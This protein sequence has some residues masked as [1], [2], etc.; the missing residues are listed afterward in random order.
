MTARWPV[1][2]QDIQ[3]FVRRR[4]NCQM[5]WPSLEKTVFEWPEAQVWERL[6]V[7]WVYVKDQ[8]KVFV[9]VYAGFCWIDAFPAGDRTTE[10]VKVYIS[11]I[12]ARI[13]I[14]KTLVSDNSPE[15]L[16]GD[17]K[18]WCESLGIKKMDST[19]YHSRANG[20]AERAV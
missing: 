12:F 14:P 9:I 4:K 3:H 15:F 2:T 17:L 20:L 18:K 1:I 19:V 5:N 6:H 11:Q 16:S 8:G 10:T 13:G 7:D